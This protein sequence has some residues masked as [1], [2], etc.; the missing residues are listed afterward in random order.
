MDYGF[1]AKIEGEFDAIA[2]GK[3]Q[4]TKMVDSFYKPFKKDI[5][6]T[7]ENAE[8]AKGE[9]E[10]GIDE[11]T[12]KKIVARMGRYGPMIQIGDV[13]DEEKPR[14]AKLK[15]TQ[16]IETITVAEA[17]E[18]FKLPLTLGEHEGKEV[19]VNAGR[20]GPY[21]KWGEEFISLPRGEEPLDVDMDRALLLIAGK[22]TA[23]APIASC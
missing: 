2:D 3:Q 8:R 14:F 7:M 17:M 23:D 12:G 10:L 18:L 5:D 16:S 20:F 21:V 9:R 11:A 1:T 22:Q 13:N 15:A 6:N 19:S 4:W